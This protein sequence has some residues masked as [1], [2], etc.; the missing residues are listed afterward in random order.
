MRNVLWI[1]ALAVVM[2]GCAN[3]SKT[4]ESP[5]VHPLRSP[6]P[7]DKL[8]KAPLYTFNE[9]EVDVYLKHLNETEKDPIRRVIHLARKNVGQPYAIFLLGEGPYEIYDP[10]PMYCLDQS[11]CVTFVE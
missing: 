10:D 1:V 9:L 8:E 6:R 5:V 3:K 11:D 2:G 7:F 4:K